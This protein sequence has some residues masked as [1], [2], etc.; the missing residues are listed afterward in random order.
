MDKQRSRYE[1]L[2]GLRSDI[3]SAD[4]FGAASGWSDQPGSVLSAVMFQ[5]PSAGQLIG[6]DILSTN[7]IPGLPHVLL[8]LEDPSTFRA[9]LRLWPPRRPRRG[10]I[11][12]HKGLG[13]VVKKGRGQLVRH[14]W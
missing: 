6:L 13:G 2:R 4:L 12:V 5:V 9:A 1:S 3:S 14:D 7:C 8:L 10:R 11:C